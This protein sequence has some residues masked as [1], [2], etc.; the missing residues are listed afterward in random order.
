MNDSAK[1][2]PCTDRGAVNTWDNSLIACV[3]WFS[4]TFFNARN[5]QEFASD[6]GLNPDDFIVRDKGINGYLK[7]AHWGHIQFYFEGHNTTSE[8]GIHLN[9]SGQGCRQ[10]EQTFEKHGKTWQ[11]VF[12]LVLAQGRVNITRLDIALDDFKGYFSIKQLE[13]CIRDGCVCSRFPTAR[14]FETISIESGRTISQ[15]IYFGKTDVIIR[16]YDKAAERKEKGY[17]LK[18]EIDCWNRTELQLRDDRALAAVE[19]I[20]NNSMELGTFVLGVLNRY[21][22]FK[23]AGT[24][25]NRARWE[26][27]RWWASYLHNVGKIRLSLVAPDKSI[28]RTRDW[29]ESQTVASIAML[30]TA[31]GSDSLLLDYIIEKGKKQMS[32]QQLDMAN[33]F[34][35]DERTRER[36]K[37]EMRQ[38][39]HENRDFKQQQLMRK[40]RETSR[41][42]L[43]YSD[44][45][46]QN[47]DY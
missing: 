16:F 45:K 32:E 9:M 11:D 33:E 25:K 13:K 41:G 47:H 18:E 28:L 2:A 31:L 17:V 5:W 29:I 44:L 8:M 35:V 37:N 46:K 15:T 3:D 7:S 10:F 12:E 22:S 23:K 40:F 19:T 34:L 42:I 27:T 39:M 30:Y 14:N 36:V 4:A 20:V 1:K 26:N 38:F 43:E 21:V 24:D 6:F